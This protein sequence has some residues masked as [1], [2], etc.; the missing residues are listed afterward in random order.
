MKL[1]LLKRMWRRILTFKKKVPN[2]GKENGIERK[3]YTNLI[4]HQ[5]VLLDEYEDLVKS[6]EE[7]IKCATD[8]A[9]CD[10][11]HSDT[12]DSPDSDLANERN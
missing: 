4:I 9:R 1:T 3:A 7:N 11:L 12:A 5:S 8:S 10:D 6:Y 2:F